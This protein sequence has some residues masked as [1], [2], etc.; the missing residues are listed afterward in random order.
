VDTNDLN[1]LLAEAK[2]GMPIITLKYGQVSIIFTMFY[3]T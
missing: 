3:Y 1:A 2:E